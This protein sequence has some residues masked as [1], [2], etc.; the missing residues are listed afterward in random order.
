MKDGAM[1]ATGGTYAALWQ[2]PQ[3]DVNK[4]FC[5]KKYTKH[6]VEACDCDPS[7]PDPCEVGR[8][9]HPSEISVPVRRF[10]M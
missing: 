8:C 9:G 5:A 10:L 2:S 7:N 1:L 4:K 6:R 3:F